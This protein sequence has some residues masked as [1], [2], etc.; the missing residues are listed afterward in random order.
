MPLDRASFIKDMDPSNPVGTID[1]VSLL[2]DVAREIKRAVKNTFPKMDG[3]VKYSTK[4]LNTMKENLEYTSE[5]QWDLKGNNLIGVK[6]FDDDS[7]VLPRSEMDK[8]YLLADGGLEQLPDTNLVLEN[9]F[10]EVDYEGAGIKAM[11][12]VMSNLMYPLGSLY[13]NAFTD[14]N[15]SKLLGVGT[16]VPYAPGR[17]IIGAGELHDGVETKKFGNE[18]SGGKFNHTLTE[19]EMPAHTHSFEYLQISKPS[20]DT[21]H[22]GNMAQYGMTEYNTASA[23][24]SK[25]HNNMQPYIAVSIW[26]RTA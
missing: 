4:D 8:R 5:K 19:Q 17:C 16:W 13:Y 25:P 11:K 20:P 26:K 10:K 2:D 24:G 3:E 7:A 6:G 12:T 22:D 23:G 15:P 21:K 18:A 14:E 9:L 1:K